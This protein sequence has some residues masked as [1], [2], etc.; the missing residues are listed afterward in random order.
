MSITYNEFDFYHSDG[1]YE[2]LKFLGGEEPSDDEVWQLAREYEQTPVFENIW[3][4]IV[5]SDICS[6]IEEQYALEADYYINA[7]DTHL[8]IGN[9]AIYN[10]NAF[11]H[12][13]LAKI[14]EKLELEA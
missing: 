13:V 4:R 5:L 7:R 3:Y 1:F 14:K 8:Y 6:A 10:L 2:I 9:E 12:A 11:K